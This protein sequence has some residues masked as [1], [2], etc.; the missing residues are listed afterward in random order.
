MGEEEGLEE[1]E[2]VEEASEEDEEVLFYFI[3]ISSYY[4]LFFFF[5]LRWSWWIS[6]K[7]QALSTVLAIISLAKLMIIIL[8]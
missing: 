8:F 3:I 1:E 6:W 4:F 5:D 7:G 2:E